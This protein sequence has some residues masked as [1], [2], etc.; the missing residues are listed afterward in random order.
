[1]NNFVSLNKFGDFFFLI[2]KL[3]LIPMQKELKTDVSYK[4]VI[5]LT[6]PAGTVRMTELYLNSY[7]P[8]CRPE[9]V[10]NY[11]TISN[12]K[13]SDTRQSFMATDFSTLLVEYIIRKV[14]ENQKELKVD[15]THKHLLDAGDANLMEHRIRTAKKK[16]Q[17]FW[18]FDQQHRSMKCSII[19][20]HICQCNLFSTIL[21]QT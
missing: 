6:T 21:Q 5:E 12:S 13:W 1:M 8:D 17:S 20:N 11:P 15:G 14:Q 18:I 10:R 19:S 7:N 3:V 4:I 2:Q 16:P 9:K